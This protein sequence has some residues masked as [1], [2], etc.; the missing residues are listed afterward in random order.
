MPAQSLFNAIDTDGSGAL[1]RDEIVQL[2]A[3]HGIV[4]DDHY[5][6]GVLDAYDRSGE[7]DLGLLHPLKPACSLSWLCF[8]CGVSGPL[9]NHIVVT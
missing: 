5:L 9:N 8:Q 6:N 1:S 7:I 4:V 2:L 3:D